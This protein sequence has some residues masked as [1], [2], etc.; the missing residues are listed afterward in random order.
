MFVQNKYMSNK[1]KFLFLGLGLF[2]VLAGCQISTERDFSRVFPDGSTS[3]ESSNSDIKQINPRTDNRYNLTEDREKFDK[4]RTEVPDKTKTI[5]DEKALILS[6]MQDFKKEPSDV[7]DK[8]NSLVRK[9]RDKFN[10][11]M[12]KIRE[13][14]AKQEKK[15]REDFLKDLDSERSDIKEK[16]LNREKSAELY[17]EIE[18]K[19]K[20]FFSKERDQREDFEGDY[21]QKRK[22]F[23]EYLKEKSDEFNF[24]LKSYTDKFND[25]KKSQN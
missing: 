23:E 18:N 5:N 9:K 16:K 11:D 13:D 8:Y 17:T 1:A 3:A 7:R 12:Q 4:L 15:R 22:D 24:E 14:F 2:V 25:L 10:D 6:W 21:R 20:E 19:R